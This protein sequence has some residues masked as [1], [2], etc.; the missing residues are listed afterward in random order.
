M[1]TTEHNPLVELERASQLIDTVEKRTGG[2]ASKKQLLFMQRRASRLMYAAIAVC[3]LISVVTAT[4]VALMM[5][6]LVRTETGIAMNTA[7][8]E[9]AIA[10]R[11][12][13]R[14]AGVAEQDLPPIPEPRPAEQGVDVDAIVDTV[15][16][17]VLAEVRND[18]RYRGPAGEPCDPATNPAC[19]G[20]EGAQG[21][22]GEPGDDGAQGEPGEPCSPEIEACRGPAGEDAPRIV[23]AGPVRNDELVC[24]FRTTLEDGTIFDSPTRDENCLPLPDPPAEDEVPE[25][26]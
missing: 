18:P 21:D 14:R 7:A 24:V 1:M 10:T 20:P 11:E 15:T 22:P 16:A 17:I 8:I 2:V 3:L 5:P 12:E 9:S 4:A 25:G 13:L 23:N 26:E 19:I 6:R